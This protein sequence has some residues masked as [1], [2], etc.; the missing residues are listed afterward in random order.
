MPG[1][2]PY[3]LQAQDVEPVTLVSNL[4]LPQWPCHHAKVILTPLS[5]RYGIGNSTYLRE[6]LRGL[7]ELIQGKYFKH[8]SA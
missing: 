8:Y 2:V 5:P 6:L 7:N 1:M 3:E 4:P